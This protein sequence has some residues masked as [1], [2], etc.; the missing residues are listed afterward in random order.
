MVWSGD[1]PDTIETIERHTE[2]IRSHLPDELL[3]DCE[4]VCDNHRSELENFAQEDRPKPSP[5]V[6]P[7]FD[8]RSLVNKVKDSPDHEIDGITEL[9]RFE[10][11]LD[12]TTTHKRMSK[13]FI[14]MVILKNG[15]D[16]Q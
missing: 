12:V 13:E 6:G 2:Y 8:G 9:Y 7:H 4:A 14:G 15:N 5:S 10:Y 3:E 16:S 1:H 11:E